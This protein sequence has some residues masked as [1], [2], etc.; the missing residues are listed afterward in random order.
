MTV[1]S[2]EIVFY[3][4]VFVLPGFI[5]NC[6]ID[7][8]NPPKKHND[9]IFFLKC[10]G[11][12]I[13]S[14]AIWSWLYLILI[15]C[16]NLHYIVKWVLLVL[17]SLIGSSIVGLVISVFKQKQ[18]IKKILEKMNVNTIHTTPTA[19][20]YIF[21]KQECSL[22]IITLLDDTQLY[23]WYSNDSFT[24]SDSD[25]RDIFVELAY[26]Y[27]NGKWTI[28]NESAGFYVPKDQIK[29]IEFKKGDDT[30]VR[31]EKHQ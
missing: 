26:S 2:F 22:V 1:D 13:I 6:I 27:K 14:C 4:A 18:I 17:I 16:D 10:L 3:T 8:I 23:G 7:S 19:W 5:V 20:D 15:K 31:E 29:Y 9:G 11:Y 25:E 12:S 28:D 24:S 21:S 30:D